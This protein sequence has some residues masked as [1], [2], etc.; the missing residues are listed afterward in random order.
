M[1]VFVL[2]FQTHFL[3]LENFNGAGGKSKLLKW[4]SAAEVTLNA[5][6]NFIENVRHVSSTKIS[7]QEFHNVFPLFA[8]WA[9]KNK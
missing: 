5:I 7:L 9:A 4:F 6:S 8:F 2:F 3:N 1:R